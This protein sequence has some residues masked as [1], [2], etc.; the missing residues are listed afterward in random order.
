MGIALTHPGL[1]ADFTAVDEDQAAVLIRE[2]GWKR[3]PASSGDQP[4]KATA[5]RTAKKAA[6][7]SPTST[8]EPDSTE[9]ES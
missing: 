8:S 4:R 5:K 2:G 7:Q 6:A 3:K 1:E 9:K